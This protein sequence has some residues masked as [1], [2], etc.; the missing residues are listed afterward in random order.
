MSDTLKCPRC[1]S[2]SITTSLNYKIKK[3]LGYAGECAIGFGAG[4][5]LGRVGLGAVAEDLVG[6]VNLHDWVEKE[7]E[8][9]SCGFNWTESNETI[10]PLSSPPEINWDPRT[11]LLNIIAW[12]DNNHEVYSEDS[13]IKSPAK[14]L[15]VALQDNGIS[16]STVSLAEI[17]TYR[18]LINLILNVST[19]QP[20]ECESD[21]ETLLFVEFI[22]AVQKKQFAKASFYGK[23]LVA[24]EDMVNISPSVADALWNIQVPPEEMIGYCNGQIAACYRILSLSPTNKETESFKETIYKLSY[25]QAQAFRVLGKYQEALKIL[26]SI[27]NSGNLKDPSIGFHLTEQMRC[28]LNIDDG[29]FFQESIKLQTYLEAISTSQAATS[30]EGQNQ[31]NEQEYLE[32]YMEYAADGEISERDR[33]MLD[34]FRVRCGITKERARELVASCSIP[35]LSEDEQEYLEL[36]KEYAADGE[37]SERDRKMLNK[38]RDRMGISVERAKEIEQL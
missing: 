14:D 38:M 23:Q 16:V 1:G 11:K 30:T 35:Q 18:D 34:K 31:I 15:R 25:Y 21:K 27:P 8:C 7:Y 20:E 6:D 37:I 29:R 24:Y 33:K 22:D 2:N 12:C 19:A 10:S 13:V 5:L 28:A 3:G 4:Y 32:L 26:A 17:K 36:Y 9:C